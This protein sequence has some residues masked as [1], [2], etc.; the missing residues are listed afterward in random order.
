VPRASTGK[1]CVL[2]AIARAPRRTLAAVLT[3]LAWLASSPAWARPAHPPGGRPAIESHG[4]RDR[5]QRADG[6]SDEPSAAPLEAVGEGGRVFLRAQVSER[7]PYVGQQV[8]L[9]LKILSA[10]PI[11]KLEFTAP[12]LEGLKQAQAFLESDYSTS[13]GGVAYRVHEYRAPLFATRDGAVEVGSAFFTCRIKL[14]STSDGSSSM[15]DDFYSGRSVPGEG[16]TDPIRLDS[17]PTPGGSRAPVGATDISAALAPLV[18][19]KGQPATLT[20]EVRTY[21]DDAA[22]GEPHIGGLDSFQVVADRPLTEWVAEPEG[23][24]RVRKVFKVALLGKTAGQYTV[25]PVTLPYV[26]PA[27]GKVKEAASEAI[28]FRVGR[29]LPTDGRAGARGAKGGGED[30]TEVIRSVHA[31]VPK[32]T[33]VD[34]LAGPGPV[35]WS[36]AVLGLAGSIG[37]MV[38]TGRSRRAAADPRWARERTA[39]RR[40]KTELAEAARAAGDA[41]AFYEQVGRV[42]RAF[43]GAK[44]DLPPGVLTPEEVEARLAAGGLAKTTA[45]EVRELLV[46]CELKRWARSASSNGAADAEA[47]EKILERARALVAR[48]D[49]ELTRTAKGAAT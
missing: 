15:F 47:R 45:T 35:G 2:A 10:V 40:A 46:S 20:V 23:G 1:T 7:T 26:D 18:V 43:V 16:R 9:T 14:G 27:T 4:R 30:E 8:V 38:S 37:A 36:M 3:L 13:E 25:P 17:R 21:G 33:A 5:L 19:K 39:M 28:P 22:V 12:K 31:P 32:R 44:I 49:E 41:P 6:S 42:V 11:Y 24:F 34:P 48:V 29:T